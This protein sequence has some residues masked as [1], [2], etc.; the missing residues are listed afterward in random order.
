M[1]S[2]VKIVYPGKK[3]KVATEEG[4]EY[5]SL[6]KGEELEYEVSDERRCVGYHSEKGEMTPCPE[7][8][9]IDSGD[10]CSECRSNDIYTGWRQG[11]GSPS[12]E[13][14]YSV[15]LAQCG[16]EL[17]VGTTRSN[18]IQNR[19]REQ[20]ADF[21]AE[22]KN[23]LD[24]REA[25]ELEAELSAKPGLKERI[26]K[27]AKIEEADSRKLS[28]K[29]DDLGFD[30]DIETV[31]GNSLNCSTLFRK[32]R[33]PSPIKGVKGQIV[34]ND[35]IGMAMGSG[36]VLREPRQKGLGEF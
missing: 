28:R 36:R 14:D 20:G 35:R 30:A 6:E 32:G 4:Y 22:I 2:I 21:A 16:S 1:K 15:Y 13:A 24:G 33:F 29:L 11:N 18:R 8:R 23:G 26:R 31:Y 12:F 3:L 19:W 9:E 27:E 17:K 25:L 7:F 5:I 34:S 10:Q